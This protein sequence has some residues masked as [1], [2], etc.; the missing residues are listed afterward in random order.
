MNI[1]DYEEKKKHGQE[2][3]PIEYYFINHTHYRYVMQLHWHKEFE[4]IRVLAGELRVFLNNI[5]YAAKTGDIIFASGHML[6]R[7][8]PIDCV[9]ECIVYDLNLIR[10]SSAGKAAEYLVPLMAGTSELDAILHPENT[11]LYRTAV[12][13]FETMCASSPFYELSVCGILSKMFYH[14]LSDGRVHQIAGRV[15][16]HRR[17]TIATL[18]DWIEKNYRDKITLRE[19]SELSGLNEKYLCRVFREFTG[20]T[21]TEYINRFRCERASFE[22]TVNRKNVTEA[23]YESGFNELSHFS[24]TFRK[25]KGIS[26]REFCRQALK[27][28]NK[29]A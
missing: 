9:Y 11:A 12:E 19:L 20:E 18:I 2:G 23:A 28:D 10:G 8:E 4:V 25:Y 1:I 16:G 7:A 24:R 22:M 15:H 14:L 5:E 29:D 27:G 6:H 13:L 17:K 21:P 26:P 3:F